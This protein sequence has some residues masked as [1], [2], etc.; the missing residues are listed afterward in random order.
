[1]DFKPQYYQTHPLSLVVKLESVVNRRGDVRFAV[2]L[3]RGE[4]ETTHYLFE[5]LSSAIDFVTSNFQ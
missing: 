4:N 1:M 2:T 3:G 5:H